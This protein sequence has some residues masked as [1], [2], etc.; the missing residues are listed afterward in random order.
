LITAIALAGAAALGGCGGGDEGG[1]TVP[2]SDHLVVSLG[3]SVASG[4]GNPDRAAHFPRRE[5]EWTV[6]RCHRSRRSGHA[7]AAHRLAGPDDPGRVVLLGCSG[8]TIG[9]GLLKPYE[10][11]AP[12]G[13]LEPAQVEALRDLAADRTV[14]AV[15]LSIGANDVGFARIVQFCI[16][17]FI[18]PCWEDRFDPEPGKPGPKLPLE[19]HV[20]LALKALARGYRNL[21][22]VLREVIPAKRVIVVEYFDPTG[23]PEGENCEMFF[24]GVTPPESEWARENILRPLNAQI[25]EAADLFGWKLVDGVD[26]RFREHGLCAGSERW[27][28]TA[29]ESI[30]DIGI[31]LEGSPFDRRTHQALLASYKGTLHPNPEGHAALAD[32]IFPVLEEVVRGGDEP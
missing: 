5:A 24:G 23:G 6:P 22:R 3:D 29:R 31:P 12:D 1:E 30:F 20:P 26:E 11:I 4:E 27:V 32:L 17:N 8:A 14:D 10:G 19:Q 7:I 9:E 2:V 28:V 25:L 16:F 13:R 21:N 18:G 15:L